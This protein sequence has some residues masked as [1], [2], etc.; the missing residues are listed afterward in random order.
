MTATQ[1]RLRRG[2]ASQCDAM[3]P[4]ADEAI[5]DTTNNRLR[6]GDGLRQ[7]GFAIPNFSDVQRQ[8]FG[9]GAAGGT[10]DALTLTLSPALL[11][12]T[13]G[14]SV[15]FRASANNT[16]AA[17]LN[18][19]GLGA[20]NIWKQVNGALVALEA[21]DIVSGL[22]YK[23]THDGTQFQL[24]YNTPTVEPS[25]LVFLG[26]VNFPSVAFVSLINSAFD[27]YL[28]DFD[29]NVSGSS[30]LA[31]QFSTNNGSSY[32]TSGY[33]NNGVANQ[34]QI[35]L[36]PQ[37]S[38]Y[39]GKIDL[40]GFNTSSGLNRKMIRSEYLGMNL[41]NQAVTGQNFGSLETS[42]AEVNAVRI[43]NSSAGLATLY[44]YTQ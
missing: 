41:S 5:S 43:L 33:N 25:G 6:I 27:S 13:G 24:Q 8:A 32:I 38:F 35:N 29:L 23:V 19:N 16:G 37:G 42:V 31:I 39:Y 28:I 22:I 2:T 3:T 18:V 36:A 11:A 20:V 40:R 15:E 30:Q 4:A 44:G 1:T 26:S 7:G 10:A 21:D 34:S 14:V 12:Y 9:Y 17:T